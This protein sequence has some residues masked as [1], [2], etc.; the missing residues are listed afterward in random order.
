MTHRQDILPIL[1]SPSPTI[2]T[3]VLSALSDIYP[4]STEPSPRSQLRALMHAVRWEAGIPT[5]DFVGDVLGGERWLVWAAGDV[6]Y[7]MDNCRTTINVV[8]GGRDSLCFASCTRG[9]IV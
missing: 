1:L 6:C 4:S 7:P 3:Y 9:L 5:S 8:L 2:P